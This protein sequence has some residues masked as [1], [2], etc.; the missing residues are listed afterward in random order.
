VAAWRETPCFSDAERASSR[1]R[2]LARPSFHK[3]SQ[4]HNSPS[5]FP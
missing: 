4:Q 1:P 2:A 3:D 5:L